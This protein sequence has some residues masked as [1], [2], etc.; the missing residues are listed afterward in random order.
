MRI[1]YPVFRAENGADPIRNHLVPSKSFKDFVT[2]SLKESDGDR[3][4]Q[5]SIACITSGS[6]TFTPGSAATSSSADC[7]RIGKVR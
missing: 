3:R 5:T 2:L 6:I 1:F 4:I 7:S